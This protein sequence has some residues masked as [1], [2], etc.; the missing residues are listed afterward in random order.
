MSRRCVLKKKKSMFILFEVEPVCGS[1]AALA[2]ILLYILW[3][4]IGLAGPPARTVI[5][6]ACCSARSLYRGSQAENL[7]AIPMPPLRSTRQSRRNHLLL[8]HAVIWPHQRDGQLLHT[9]CPTA[10]WPRRGRP[11]T[12][13]Q[14]KRQHWQGGFLLNGWSLIHSWE[15]QGSLWQRG[16]RCAVSL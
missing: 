14:R 1:P 3:G 15:R 6:Q 4:W 16:T 13:T 5:A 8:Q 11:A 2:C 12:G 7:C 9:L 10:P